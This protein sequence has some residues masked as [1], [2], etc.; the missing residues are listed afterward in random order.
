MF[1]YKFFGIGLLNGVVSFYGF[2]FL[3]LSFRRM[4]LSKSSILGYIQ[5]VTVYSISHFWFD[6]DIY[7]LDIVG[8]TIIILFGIIT[9][10]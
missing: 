5:L 4:D 9:S 10:V 8:I 3:S 7:F 1:D 2:Y 6:E